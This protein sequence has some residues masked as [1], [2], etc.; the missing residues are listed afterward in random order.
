MKINRLVIYTLTFSTAVMGG[1][2]IVEKCLAGVGGGQHAVCCT[3]TL[4]TLLVLDKYPNTGTDV[5]TRM[6]KLPISMLILV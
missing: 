5:D 3:P 2:T 6:E 4:C 1:T